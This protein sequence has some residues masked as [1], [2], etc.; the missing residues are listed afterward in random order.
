MINF[1]AKLKELEDNMPPEHKKFIEEL[2]VKTANN[3]Y[4][5][6][7]VTPFRLRNGERIPL[8]ETDFFFGHKVYV[9]D[10]ENEEKQIKVNNHL[11]FSFGGNW[12]YYFNDIK[13]IIEKY[14]DDLLNEENFCVDAGG[15][16]YIDGKEFVEIFEECLK[17]E[18]ENR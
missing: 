10:N 11:T 7:K 6:K 15:N 5:S 2:K 4:L 12:S 8:A 14:R 3:T 1:I 13:K 16:I 17:I 18:F 9:C